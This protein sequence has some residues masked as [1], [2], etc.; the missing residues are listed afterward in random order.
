[1]SAREQHNLVMLL[2]EFGQASDRYVES[3]GALYATHRTDM[4]ALSIIMKYEQRSLLPSPRDLSRDLQLSSPATTAMLDRLEKLGMI[5]R[6]RSD[7]D[8]RVIRIAMTPKAR[9][10][11]ME[12]FMP[13]GAK[14]REVISHYD[15]QQLQVI[16]R[17]MAEAVAGVDSAREEVVTQR[18]TKPAKS[19]TDTSLKQ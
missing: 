10:K 11:G 1:M 2:Q 6:Q 5:E 17:F 13:L 14:M 19:A 12:M 9:G 15:E 7:R 18:A 8:R 3:T 4:N 16:A